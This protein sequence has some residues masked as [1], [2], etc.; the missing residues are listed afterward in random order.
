MI[1]LQKYDATGLESSNTKTIFGEQRG[2]SERASLAHCVI[3][4]GYFVGE[5]S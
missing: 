2:T 5:I 4:L 3:F 1:Q